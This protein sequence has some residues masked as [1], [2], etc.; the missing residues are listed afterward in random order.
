ME[1][2][3][4]EFAVV[5]AGASGLMAAGETAQAGPTLVLEAKQRPGKKGFPEAIGI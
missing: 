1:T 2:H 3:Q 5:G 4:V